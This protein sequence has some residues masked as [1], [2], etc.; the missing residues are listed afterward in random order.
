MRAI[1]IGISREVVVLD[2]QER[3]AYVAGQVDLAALLACLADR[4][5]ADYY[6]EPQA[7]RYQ[8]SE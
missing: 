2:E 7:P 8:L 5:R 4:L 1:N 3:D 6:I